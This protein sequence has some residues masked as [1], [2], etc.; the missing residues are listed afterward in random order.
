MNGPL[1]PEPIPKSGLLLS[2]EPIGI[3]TLSEGKLATDDNDQSDD[4]DNSDHGQ[5]VPRGTN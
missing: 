4:S 2:V 1:E 5:T 3:M